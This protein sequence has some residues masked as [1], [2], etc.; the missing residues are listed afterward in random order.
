MIDAQTIATNLAAIVF[1][2]SY[3]I[4]LVAASVSSRILEQYVGAYEMSATETVTV[5]L[6]A[7]KLFAPGTG[8]GKSRIYPLSETRFFLKNSP[9]EITFEKD[10][11]GRVVTIS[12]WKNGKRT[13]I[14]RNLP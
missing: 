11:A 9:V 7:G 6:E 10:A 4:P 14:P 2:K 8:Q 1:D 3:R 5:T 13:Q 12:L